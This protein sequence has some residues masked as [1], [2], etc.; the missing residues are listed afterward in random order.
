[1][2][3]MSAEVSDLSSEFQENKIFLLINLE[4]KCVS[5]INVYISGTYECLA[6]HGS[7]RD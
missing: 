6:S 2:S 5:E 3:D 7:Q 4:K 1:M